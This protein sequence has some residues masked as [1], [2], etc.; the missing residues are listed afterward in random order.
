MDIGTFRGV[1]TA[2]LM[3]LFVALV[4]WAYSRRR[5]PEFSEAAALPLEDDAAPRARREDL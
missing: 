4:Y 3:A 5:H 2:L 1:V